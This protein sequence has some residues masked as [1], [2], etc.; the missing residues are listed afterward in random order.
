[1]TFPFWS[2]GQI[3]FEAAVRPL[4][5]SEL[6]RRRSNIVTPG[7]GL[8]FTACFADTT[9]GVAALS[10]HAPGHRVPSIGMGRCGR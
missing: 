9:T 5:I 2:G 7:P 4:S 10:S 3:Q 6:P 8:A 1:M